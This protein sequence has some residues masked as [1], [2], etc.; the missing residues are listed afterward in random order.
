MDKSTKRLADFNTY[1]E[2]NCPA[3]NLI[4]TH[5]HNITLDHYPSI[6]FSEGFARTQYMLAFEC[7]LDLTEQATA[8]RA[9]LNDRY[10]Y[11]ANNLA[12]GRRSKVYAQLLVR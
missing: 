3:P 9:F 5:G 8:F 2:A 4:F 11:Q 6:E 7:K 12:F 1:I 10:C